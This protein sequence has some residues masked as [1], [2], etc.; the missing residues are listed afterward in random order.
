MIGLWLKGLITHRTARVAGTTLG[1]AL[2]VALILSLG[3]FLTSSSLSMTARAAAAVPIDWQ[4]ELVP[5]ADANA[6]RDAIGKAARINALHTVHFAQSDG[7]VAATG[8]TTQMT[9]PG[10]VIAFDANYLKDFPREV[11]LLTGTP[12]GVLVAQQTAANLHVGPGDK[13]TI[14]RVG[15][16]PVES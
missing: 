5:S 2:A 1:I 16:S 13:V 15:L 12:D 6:V 14:N 3:A 4:V 11:R 7:F 8:S 10:K 9:G